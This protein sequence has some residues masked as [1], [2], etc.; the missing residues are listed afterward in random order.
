MKN[1]KL[2][3]IAWLFVLAICL[4]GGILLTSAVIINFNI[5]R[6]GVVWD[7]FQLERSEKARLDSALRAAVGYGG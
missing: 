6:V 3:S 4:S 7:D 1:L 2:K 5:E